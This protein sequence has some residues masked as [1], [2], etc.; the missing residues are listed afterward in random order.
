MKETQ[1][2]PKS[3]THYRQKRVKLIYNPS[4]GTA[5]ESP[6][7]ILDVVHEM[8][9]W[10]LVPE[11]YLVEPDSNLAEM[12]QDALSRG[13]RLFVVC[14]GDG[15]IS[16]IT[17][18][19]VG[20]RAT[21][22]IIP[23]GTQNNTALSLGI[24]E[25]IPAAVAILRTG[26]RI[27]VD[28]GR[29]SCGGV[30]TPFLEVCSVGLVSELFPSG[31]DIQHG[32][33]GKVGEFLSTL[34]ASP[35][36]EMHL[37]L[38]GKLDLDSQGYVVLV[39]NMPH[40]FRRYRVSASAACDDGLLDV[41]FYAD[42]SKLELLSYVLLGVGESM[43]EDPHVQY[44]RARSLDIETRPAMAVMA[45]G[46]AL[47]EGGVHIEVRKRSLGVMVAG[48]QGKQPAPAKAAAAHD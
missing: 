13:I 26:K 20:T 27:K 6:L 28:T 43:T 11:T 5:K 2:K 39:S 4:A 18:L 17:Y 25:D 30:T 10:K 8:Q 22:G 37:N 14:G 42:L 9:S 31:D 3:S 16:S 47:G 12:V 36:A 45:D 29:V 34:A 23:L 35:P 38:D 21:L 46:Y 33:L 19:L 48:G 44:F 24:P 41:L 32:N 7:N 15:T 40:I 1:N